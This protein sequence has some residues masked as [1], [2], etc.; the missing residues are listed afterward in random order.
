MTA[1]A[2]CGLGVLG[3]CHIT[4]MENSRV[5]LNGKDYQAGTFAPCAETV[6]ARCGLAPTIAAWRGS[7]TGSSPA[8]P[9]GTGS[10]ITA[11]FKFSKMRA[12]IFGLVPI[13]ESI[14]YGGRN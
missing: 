9:R 11:S 3:G 7:K 6:M 4:R 5:G 10:S 13:T 12:A 2:D 14:G 1:R 8:T